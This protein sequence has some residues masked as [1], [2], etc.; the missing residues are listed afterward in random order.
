MATVTY[1]IVDMDLGQYDHF[2]KLDVD[3]LDD[4]LDSSYQIWGSGNG[5]ITVQVRLTTE[6]QIPMTQ[7]KR[8]YFEYW[9]GDEH[10]ST[11]TNFI[12]DG[13]HIYNNEVVYSEKVECYY[14]RDRHCSTNG[15][16][17]FDILKWCNCIS[18]QTLQDYFVAIGDQNIDYNYISPL[19]CRERNLYSYITKQPYLTKGENGDP[20]TTY[21]QYGLKGTDYFT[22]DLCM[23]EK[24]CNLRCWTLDTTNYDYELCWTLKYPNTIYDNDRNILIPKGSV[25]N[26][27]N[28]IYIAPR[29]T[30]PNYTWVSPYR[31]DVTIFLRKYQG[32]TLISETQEY[33]TFTLSYLIHFQDFTFYDS[34]HDNDSWLATYRPTEYTNFCNTFNENTDFIANFSEFTL[35]FHAYVNNPSNDY[36]HRITLYTD[37]EKTELYCQRGTISTTPSLN[38]KN[39]DFNFMQNLETF[40]LPEKMIKRFKLEIELRFNN[41]SSNAVIVWYGY[42]PVIPHFNGICSVSNI[43]KC[44]ENGRQLSQDENLEHN[45]F[46]IVYDIDCYKNELFNNNLFTMDKATFKINTEELPSHSTHEY[47]QNSYTNN[48]GDFYYESRKRA[49]IIIPFRLY[50]DYLY[51]LYFYTPFLSVRIYNNS[52]SSKKPIMN[53]KATGN[54]MAIGKISENEDYLEVGYDIMTTN[55]NYTLGLRSDNEKLIRMYN[56][57][58][59]AQLE[60]HEYQKTY[61]RYIDSNNVYRYPHAMTLSVGDSTKS[62]E[63]RLI[64]N[65]R[66]R[67]IM[68]YNSHDTHTSNIDYT[69]NDQYAKYNNIGLGCGMLFDIRQSGLSADNCT[70]NFYNFQQGNLCY[71]D[72][73]LGFIVSVNSSKVSSFTDGTVIKWGCIVQFYINIVFNDSV[74]SGDF[75][76]THVFTF[77]KDNF[78]PLQISAIGG[79]DF[80]SICSG[81]ILKDGKVYISSGI[82]NIQSGTKATVS[83]MYF[84]RFDQIGDSY[85]SIHTNS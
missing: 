42:F 52:F 23:F 21:G 18:N 45:Y 25:V 75:T 62:D 8:L 77:T 74:G 38:S 58:F 27:N 69:T 10:K 1:N 7:N 49:Y 65:L 59:A 20:M 60:P 13:S 12:I 19:D 15:K 55:D 36:I 56:T 11:Y 76:D 2:F 39:C 48:K 34:M 30:Y 31:E 6:T 47:I 80:G 29:D 33:F 41:S 83:G 37:N 24:N 50:R 79:G 17:I 63:F 73:D 44:D 43:Y 14:G 3:I 78:K 84:T 57:S 54:S 66:N 4:D 82:G 85:P 61:N 72:A 70:D 51:S 46:K 5:Y 68:K 71:K 67:P 9:F 81:R 28:T 22:I 35:N 32:N 16:F 40:F 26:G 64:D 53:F